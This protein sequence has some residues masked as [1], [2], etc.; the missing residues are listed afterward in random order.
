VLD[1]GCGLGH[2]LK[3]LRGAW[4][5]CQLHGVEWS[6]VLALLSRL[7]CP[8]ARVRRGDMW[9]RGWGAFDLVYV[10]QRP[11][12]M[13]RAWRKACSEMPAGGWLVSLEFAVPGVRPWARIE[14]GRTRVLWFY[15]VPAPARSN[16][17][18]G[19]NGS[20]ATPRGR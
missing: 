19:S 16:G 6:P 13:A 15:C 9:R 17:S 12:S 18:N 5:A 1:A 14:A 7:R 10:F 11:E 20:M 3:A 2:G 4:P 8:W